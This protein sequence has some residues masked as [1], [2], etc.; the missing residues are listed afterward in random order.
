MTS[1]QNLRSN[2]R[3]AQLKKEAELE[4]KTSKAPV[5]R[6]V[7]VM[8]FALAFV[9]ALAAIG[10]AQAA[11]DFSN[12]TSLIQAVTGLIPAFMDL[13][14]AIAPLIVTIAIIAFVVTFLDKILSMLNKF[15]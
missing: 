2:L 5:T 13:V 12:I 6:G 8:P 11:I 4:D 7:F 10:P 14:I 3:I 9:F 1:L 15:T